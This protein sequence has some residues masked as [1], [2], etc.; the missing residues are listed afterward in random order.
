MKEELTA[1]DLKYN[2]RACM[3]TVL[4]K[5][6]NALYENDEFIF[7]K[8]YSAEDYYSPDETLNAFSL[9]YKNA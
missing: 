1:W 7:E 2:I 3:C 9:I 5:N 6:K 4:K 8:N